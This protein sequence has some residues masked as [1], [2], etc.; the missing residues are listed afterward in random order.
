VDWMHLAED[1]DKYGQVASSCE[2][3]DET[4]GSIKGEGNFL[5]SRVTASQRL[6][7]RASR[8]DRG[9]KCKR[10]RGPKKD[11]CGRRSNKEE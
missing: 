8:R 3:G 4:S 1:R 6:C 5:T 7:S 10:S 2:H 11:K 9:K